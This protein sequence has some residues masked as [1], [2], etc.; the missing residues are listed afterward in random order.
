MQLMRRKKLVLEAAVLTSLMAWPI[1]AGANSYLG[2]TR[3]GSDVYEVSEVPDTF[4]VEDPRED[5]SVKGI[6]EGL[7]ALI[8]D[9]AESAKKADFTG[10]TIAMEGVRLWENTA[11]TIG[12]DSTES[13]VLNG[14]GNAGILAVGTAPGELPPP[15][16]EV[17]GKTISVATDSRDASAIWI[18]NNTETRVAPEACSRVLLLADTIQVTSP[19]TAILNYSNGDFLAEG[20]VTIK[21]PTAIDVRGYSHTSINPYGDGRTVVEGDVRF[22]TPDPEKGETGGAVID[23][24]VDLNFNGPDSYW[25][26]RSYGVD[27]GKE[28]VALDRDV[29]AI[30]GFGVTLKNGAAWTV[31]GDSLVNTLKLDHGRIHMAPEAQELHIGTVSMDHGTLNLQGENQKVSVDYFRG[32]HDVVRT[33][34]LS[35]RVVVKAGDEEAHQITVSAPGPIGDAI[36]RDPSKAEKLANVVT[37]EGYE[38]LSA[39]T[40]VEVDEGVLAGA[41]SADI[42]NGKIDPDTISYTPNV[43]NESIASLATMN[44]MTWRQE[45]NDM[46]K[47][48]GELRDSEGQQGIWARMV[49]GEAKYGA[50]NMKNQYNYYQVG[51]DHK[52]GKNW[53]VGAAYSKTDGTTSFSRGTADNDHDGLAIYGSWLGDDGSFVDL[54]GKYAHLD[55]DYNV[56][57]GAGSAD[58]DNDAFSFSAEYGKRF[59]GQ[60]GFWIEPQVELTYGTVDSA[61]YTT[62]RG[63][64]VHHDSTDSFVGR[65]GFS[66]GKDIKAGHL[67]ARA[68]Y[69]YDF[70]G[71]T[72]VTMT[73][74]GSK[75][76]FS[77]DLGGGWWEVGVGANL[78]LSKASHLYIDV[79]KTYGGD[80]ATP[81]QW[82][83]GY[84][85]SF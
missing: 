42:T 24:V 28:F 51:Y 48:L 38:E 33:Q 23:A 15:T 67:Y 68:S 7:P 37:M 21:A 43:T 70:D 53:T 9:G 49:R 65:L 66:V 61:D 13:V 69:L 56:S 6:P 59:H 32:N 46:N 74:N 72:D 62:D 18:Q 35:N 47:R 19:D 79:E 27:Q 16:L 11:V 76:R 34:S 4:S 20:N 25:K 8:L 10:K 81:W 40:R 30:T 39:A 41:M 57:G 12:S 3:V 84:R 60:N 83:I 77:D 22:D 52:V 44:I 1:I 80:V 36:L 50:R 5:L 26:G 31:T 75:A 63:V 78:N 45:N 82:G 64:K 54:I 71:D 58:Y 29:N 17:K 2:G 55:T 14:A 85:Y 73:Y